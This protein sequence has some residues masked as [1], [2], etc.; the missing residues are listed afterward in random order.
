MR[1]RKNKAVNLQTVAGTP[2]INTTQGSKVSQQSLASKQ[3]LDPSNTLG[4]TLM[5]SNGANSTASKT[6]QSP[7]SD[8]QRA[9]LL[10]NPEIVEIDDLDLLGLTS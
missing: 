2:D 5:H 10:L 6:D 4:L 3:Y 8:T 9:N 7:P 1:R